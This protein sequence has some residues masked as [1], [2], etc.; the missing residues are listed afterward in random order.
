VQEARER[1]KHDAVAAGLSTDPKALREG[2]TGA[3]AYAD[4]VGVY[5]GFVISSLS[6]R[7]TTICTWD[8]GGP[9]WGTKTRNTFARQAIPMSWDFAE[10]N[11]LSTQSGSIDNSLDYTAKGVQLRRHCPWLRASSGCWNSSDKY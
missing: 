5:L 11:P 7:M 2:G 8:Y 3:T 4:A 6:D 10:V 1:V 9:T